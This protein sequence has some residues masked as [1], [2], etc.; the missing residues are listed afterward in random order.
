[1]SGV[2]LLL[3]L[4]VPILEL[5]VIVQVGQAIGTIPTLAL[6]V[7]MSVT[8][9]WLMKREGLGVLRRAQ[10]QVRDGRVPSRE[11]ADGFLIVLGGALMLTPGFVSDMAGMALLLP[12][13]R[14]VVRPVLLG[15]LQVMALGAALGPAA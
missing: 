15:R 3:F 12:P 2:L 7:L 14:A 8:G 4:V 13:V 6:L 1:M 5:A 11:V 10:R 9:A